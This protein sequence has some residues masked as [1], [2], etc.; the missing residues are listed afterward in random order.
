MTTGPC[1]SNAQGELDGIDPDIHATYSRA[2]SVASEHQ[3]R[4]NLVASVRYT[5]NRIKFPIEDIGV[6]DA[7][8][9]EV[10]VIG[11][12]GYGLRGPKLDSL[13]VIKITLKPG[14][15]LFRESDS[16]LRRS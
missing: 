9:N 3:L 11:N 7:E 5:R 16:Q 6:F 14:Q 10:Y 1:R 15:Q 4:G 12:P 2:I 13:S 8:E